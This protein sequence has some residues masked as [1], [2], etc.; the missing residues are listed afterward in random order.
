MNMSHTNKKTPNVYKQK[1]KSMNLFYEAA[2]WVTEHKQTQLPNTNSTWGILTLL[3]TQTETLWG[4]W[5]DLR[6][7]WWGSLVALALLA[8]TRLVN[9]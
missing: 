7:F 1:G 3:H 9:V 8:Q 4:I 2:V 5:W 6:E